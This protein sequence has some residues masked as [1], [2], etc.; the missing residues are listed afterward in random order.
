MTAKRA[1]CGGEL[2]VRSGDVIGRVYFHR[3]SIA[4]P[5]V[6]SFS[7]ISWSIRSEP[8]W[9]ELA[10]R[11]ER[12]PTASRPVSGPARTQQLI[13]EALR[14]SEP[15][16]ASSEASA[17]L[18]AFD[19]LGAKLDGDA[20]AALLRSW[21]VRANRTGSRGGAAADA[22]TKRE[23]EVL[24]LLGEGLSNP[25]IAARLHLSRKTVEH[26]VASVLSK[27][28]LRSRA[29]AAAEAVRR[30]NAAATRSR[31]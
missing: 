21:G 10:Y 19:K 6:P 12:S 22:P 9:R 3:G 26:H 1:P 8:Q 14:E 29:E 24:A 20:C 15:E 31:T 7:C 16:L 17:A 28:G 5:A 4:W 11:C 27:L 25:A 2:V 23:Q 30:A 13:A 18:G